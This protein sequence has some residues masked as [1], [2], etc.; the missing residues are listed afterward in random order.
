[1][2]SLTVCKAVKWLCSTIQYPFAVLVPVMSKTSFVERTNVV[3]SLEYRLSTNRRSI[4]TY[5][6]IELRHD[7]RRW[8]SSLRRNF[9]LS[10]N[11][12]CESHCCSTLRGKVLDKLRLVGLFQPYS[13]SF[14]RNYR[15]TEV[16]QEKTIGAR[17]IQEEGRFD[18]VLG[19][20]FVFE[21]PTV[22]L[23][24]V[25]S[26]SAAVRRLI[27]RDL[28]RRTIFSS[29]ALFSHKFDADTPESVGGL[30]VQMTVDCDWTVCLWLTIFPIF[31]II[32]YS[33][34]VYL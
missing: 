22:I 2:D 34:V 31:L 11:V 27:D 10:L 29:S 3:S 28:S 9:I 14:D 25:R 30:W 6:Q 8:S 24:T 16:R 17:T 1:M 12:D 32:I 7:L 23:N 20:P 5:M 21:G 19:Q 18:S 15:W 13:D 26:T 33:T 4:W